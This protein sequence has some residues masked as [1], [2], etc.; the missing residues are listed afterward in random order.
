MDEDISVML[1]LIM[2]SLADLHKKVDAL[3]V[4]NRKTVVPRQSRDDKESVNPNSRDVGRRVNEVMA[5]DNY[6]RP[7]TQR[8]LEEIAYCAAHNNQFDNSAGGV[9]MRNNA[10]PIKEWNK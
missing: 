4:T 5:G 8:Q 3:E 7:Y 9:G 10:T 2:E 1:K 6:K